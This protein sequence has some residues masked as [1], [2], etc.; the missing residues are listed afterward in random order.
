MSFSQKRT[1]LTQECLRRLRNTKIELGAE[2]QKLHL[3]RFMLKLKKSG[4]SQK[5]RTEILDSGLK[6]FEKMV[7]D[8]KNG[9]K[10]MYR[11]KE[12]NHDK[13]KSL[14]EKKRT[15]WW[16]TDRSKIQYKSVLFVTPTPGGVWQSNFRK[17][18]KNLTKTQ[19]RESKL[20]K[21]GD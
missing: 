11:S 12:W 8:D 2:V 1:I 15:N 20:W 14:K 13:R 19:K 6:A 7:E 4:Y 5:F 3:N 9:V 10:P 17:G 21:R 18:R 16:N